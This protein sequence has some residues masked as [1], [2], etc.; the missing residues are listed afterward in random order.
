M[1][2]YKSV[3]YYYSVSGGRKKLVK[4]LAHFIVT[5]ANYHKQA[6]CELEVAESKPNTPLQG[7]TYLTIFYI[8]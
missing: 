8:L 7:R 5:A 3:Y 6:V 4:S 1:A 2:L